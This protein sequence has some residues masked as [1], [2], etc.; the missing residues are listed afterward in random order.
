M[1]ARR[2][3]LASGLIKKYI[4]RCDEKDKRIQELEKQNQAL[5]ATCE[6]LSDDYVNLNGRNQELKSAIRAFETDYDYA[7][8]QSRSEFDCG[9][10]IDKAVN[11]LLSVLTED[12]E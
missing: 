11:K 12:K 6:K 8:L 5:S 2:F 7:H 9:S 1:E 10:R 3:N 4:S